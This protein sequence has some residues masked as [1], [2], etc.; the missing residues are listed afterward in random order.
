MTFKLSLPNVHMHCASLFVLSVYLFDA[1]EEVKKEEKKRKNCILRFANFKV[2]QVDK[3]N[4]ERPTTA[5]LNNIVVSARNVLEFDFHA[6]YI[7]TF[8]RKSFA[9]HVI[10]EDVAFSRSLP[11]RS[12]EFSFSLCSIATYRVIQ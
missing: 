2:P 3:I 11:G 12:L 4:S 8:D 5:C 1:G 7:G 6:T 9:G 10:R